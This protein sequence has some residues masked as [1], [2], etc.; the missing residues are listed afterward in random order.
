[1][2]S[3]NLKKAE[4]LHKDYYEPI[5]AITIKDDDKLLEDGGK[6]AKLII[7]FD[8]KS[9]AWEV[10]PPEPILKILIIVLI[11]ISVIT[12][13]YIFISAMLPKGT[14]NKGGRRK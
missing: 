12:A 10:K 7:E 6:N 1:K 4:K 14:K 13:L 8:K 11:A 2:I 3:E 5:E 9:S